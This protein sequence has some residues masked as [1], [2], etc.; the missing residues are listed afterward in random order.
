MITEDNSLVG[1][2]RA[3]TQLLG[4][5]LDHYPGPS[6]WLDNPLCSRQEAGFGPAE[7]I[8]CKACEG[9]G[10]RGR[11]RCDRC[12][13]KKRITV[14]HYDSEQKPVG[15]EETGPVRAMDELKRGEITHA[16]LRLEAQG[17][18]DALDRTLTM[19]A[20]HEKRRSNLRCYKDLSRALQ[21]LRS[22]SDTA[23]FLCV[24]VYVLGA[25]EPD[26]LLPSMRWVLVR[27]L[28]FLAGEMPERF[29]VP[30]ELRGKSRPEQIRDALSKGKSQSEV[31]KEFG[32]DQSTVSRAK[33]GWGKKEAA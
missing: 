5:Y 32:V 19:L 20:T 33:N 13:G 4:G 2:M 9:T 30:E 1:R 10:K 17:S 25:Q 29:V 24:W 26:H 6:T 12:R 21:A 28:A 23:H 7:T 27:G 22:Q 16:L 31:A 11:D 3:V 15:D 8:G 18:S 14:D